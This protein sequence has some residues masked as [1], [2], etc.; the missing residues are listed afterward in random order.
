MRLKSRWGCQ[1][2]PEAK[3]A[4]SFDG[5]SGAVEISGQILPLVDASRDPITLEFVWE[6]GTNAVQDFNANK[7]PM[8]AIADFIVNVGQRRLRSWVWKHG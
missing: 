1:N 6:M 7:E 3:T 2:H 5:L 8:A 4:T